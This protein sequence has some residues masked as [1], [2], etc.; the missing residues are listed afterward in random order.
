MSGFGLLTMY[1]E[2]Y[3]PHEID[4]IGMK[5]AQTMLVGKKWEPGYG[6]GIT[7]SKK[8]KP[9]APEPTGSRKP[10]VRPVSSRPVSGK[11]RRTL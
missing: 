8:A 3:D 4:Y 6:V 2:S 5:I 11:A 10:V 9:V 7:Q 1:E